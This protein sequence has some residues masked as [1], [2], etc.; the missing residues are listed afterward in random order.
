MNLP[1]RLI[2]ADDHEL[3][4]QGLK[5][6]LLR[7][8]DM[9]VVGEADS[10]DA[11]INKV[12]K[13]P[14]DILLLDLQMD[15]WAIDEI[16]H[17]AIH[18]R[19]LVLTANENAET[20]LTAIRLGARA[21]VQKRYAV[22]TLMTAIRRVADG[23]IWMPPNLQSDIVG[24]WRAVSSSTLTNREVEIV[25]YVASG[26]RNVEVAKHLSISEATVKTHLN[27]I[28]S[29]LALRD[30]V[31]LV[32]YAFRTGLVTGSPSQMNS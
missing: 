3:F 20:A 9:Q 23:L 26:L 10:V 30:R 16:R 19:V 7:Q 14:C 11:L 32:L 6:L 27:N 22:Q 17:L 4:R 15:R 31:E 5:S 24:Q 18:T 21:I 2:I 25:R 12:G 8:R 29:K 28:F 1:V 13:L